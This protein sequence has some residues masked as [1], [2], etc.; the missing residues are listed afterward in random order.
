MNT[1]YT[2]YTRLENVISSWT[3]RRRGHDIGLINYVGSVDC[4]AYSSED[5]NTFV[6][7]SMEPYNGKM[8]CFICVPVWW[9]F[10]NF[11][12]QSIPWNTLTHVFAIIVCTRL[13]RTAATNAANCCWQYY[14]L[15][16]RATLIGLLLC[17][18]TLTARVIET[19]R[20]PPHW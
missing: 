10:H 3:Q 8:L 17:V 18:S 12:A 16:G 15:D 19:T 6:M 2:H 13:Q 7:L 14:W 20:V 5:T 9:M 4:L 1:Y 11:L